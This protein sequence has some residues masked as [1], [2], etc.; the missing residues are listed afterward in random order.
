MPKLEECILISN[1]EYCELINPT[2]IG[3]TRLDENNMY[4][5][6]WEQNGV[7][8]KTHNKL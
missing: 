6:I 8:Y 5:M 4:H 1:T 3:Q 7:Y 2:F